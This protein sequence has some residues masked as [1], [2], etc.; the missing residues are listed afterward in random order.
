[1]SYKSA[2]YH[3]LEAQISRLE[4]AKDLIDIAKTFR[5]MKF[6]GSMT[7]STA[8]KM[9]QPADFG[10]HEVTL[11]DGRLKHMTLDMLAEY[12]MAE[13]DKVLGEEV[14]DFD[15]RGAAKC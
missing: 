7:L 4:R 3:N 12:F 11:T 5:S 14:K 15:V 13:A 1:M 10:V 6:G 2:D 9:Y 8:S